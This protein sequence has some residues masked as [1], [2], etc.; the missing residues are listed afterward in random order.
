MTAFQNLDELRDF[1]ESRFG[2]RAR[3][4]GVIRDEGE[5]EFALYDRFIFKAS[6]DPRTG[7]FGFGLELSEHRV[8]KTL[9]GERFSL[10]NDAESVLASLDRAERF[11]RLALP[12]KMLEVYD[13]L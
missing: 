3:V 10:N 5:I 1:I 7:V 13:N 4:L 9:L 12:D 2:A 8:T 6:I 11:C